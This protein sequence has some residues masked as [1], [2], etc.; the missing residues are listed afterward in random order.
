MRTC[1]VCKC[2][3]E[4]KELLRFVREDKIV[5]VDV[6]HNIPGRGF[7]IC[8]EDLLSVK[9]SALKKITGVEKSALLSYLYEETEKII[10]NHLSSLNKKLKDECF[11]LF[12]KDKE[13][14]L[15]FLREMEN[16]HINVE[17]I[18]IMLSRLDKIKQLN[19]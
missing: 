6:E 8:Y 5:R 9:D 4:K 15:A 14:F 7:Y 19:F 13:S 10:F 12:L 11:E 17:N 3:F 18:D 2:K 1:I 16:K